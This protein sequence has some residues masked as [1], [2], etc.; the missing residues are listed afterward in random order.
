MI[1]ILLQTIAH[2]WASLLN[3]LM[4][5]VSLLRFRE[6]LLDYVFKI[7]WCPGKDHLVADAMSRAPVFPGSDDPDP[8]CSLL[9]ASIATD[10]LFEDFLACAKSDPHYIKL[11]QCLTNNDTKFT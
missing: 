3:L 10:P 4:N 5:C 7:R 6:K 9:R 2:S 11:I 8:A 1:S